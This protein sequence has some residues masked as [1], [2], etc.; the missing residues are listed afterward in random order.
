MQ[1]TNSSRR[2]C[3]FSSEIACYLVSDSKI[4]LLW[5]T[6][7]STLL[8]VASEHSSTLLLATTLIERETKKRRQETNGAA[9]SPSGTFQPRL[10]W[11]SDVSSRAHLANNAWRASLTLD[12]GGRSQRRKPVTEMKYQHSSPL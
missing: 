7:S 1:C 4:L 2:G 5:L 11:L 3:F 6:S 8:S 12:T 10:P 9:S